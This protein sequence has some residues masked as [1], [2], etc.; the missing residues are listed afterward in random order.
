MSRSI[1][2]TGTD[3]GAGKTWVTAGLVKHLLAC[4]VDALALKPIASGMMASG[5]NEDVGV[6]LDAQPK[7]S[8]KTINF[9]TFERP[10]APALAANLAQQ[11]LDKAALLIWQKQQETHADVILIEGVGGL[12]V[13]LIATDACAWLVSDWLAEMAEAEV[14]LVVPLRLG[15]MNHAL[16]S[17]A[18]LAQMGRVPKW[19]VLNDIEKNGTGEA[20]KATLIPSL[21][22]MFSELPQVLCVSDYSDLSSVQWLD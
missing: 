14:L 20:T 16:L 11:Q 17:C 18:L 4:G 15:C 7:L 13:P 22:T 2:I 21:Q 5:V 12:M 10:L 19:I 3:T 1:F 6:L 8:A 9:K